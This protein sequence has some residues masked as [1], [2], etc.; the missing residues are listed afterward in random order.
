MGL[1]RCRGARSPRGVTGPSGAH[2]AP[3]VTI[4]S[5][6]H[7]GLG[8]YGDALDP[9]ADVS[10]M[11]LLRCVLRSSGLLYLSVPIGPDVT[12]WNLHRRY[13][14]ERLPLLLRG[15]E[16]VAVY[17]WR[18]DALDAAAS[19]TRSYEPVMVLRP[20]AGACKVPVRA[21]EEL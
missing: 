20:R 15:W 8:R 10:M 19:F 13:G 16:V 11:R 9:D 14:R 18:S 17:G 1:C 12:V 5:V 6:D 7:S 3:Q 4:S 21:A 2:G